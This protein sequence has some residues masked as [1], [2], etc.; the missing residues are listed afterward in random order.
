MFTTAIYFL[1]EQGI[2]KYSIIHPLGAYPVPMCVCQ[3]L[4]G[5]IGLE[6]LLIS[7]SPHEMSIEVVVVVVYK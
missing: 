5:F 3:T 1:L 2:C 4:I 6:G 7:D